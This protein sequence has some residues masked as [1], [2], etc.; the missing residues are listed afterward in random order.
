MDGETRSCKAAPTHSEEAST[1]NPNPGGLVANM[2]SKTQKCYDKFIIHQKNFKKFVI[3][4]QVFTTVFLI[5]LSKCQ[6]LGLF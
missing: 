3:L 4:I 1:I 5:I 2:T 6:D